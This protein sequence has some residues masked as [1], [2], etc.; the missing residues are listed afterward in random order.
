MLL[1]IRAIVVLLL[2]LVFFRLS[3]TL[4]IVLEVDPPDAA[5]KG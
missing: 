1:L 4:V 5:G 2:A 3:V